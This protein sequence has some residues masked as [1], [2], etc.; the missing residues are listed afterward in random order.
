MSEAAL[1][2]VDEKQ[3]ND[4]KM[5]PEPFWWNG[6]SRVLQTKSFNPFRFGWKSNGR[7]DERA[8]FSVFECTHE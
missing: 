6:K 1:A 2:A 7:R 5:E 3:L 8:S 4:G